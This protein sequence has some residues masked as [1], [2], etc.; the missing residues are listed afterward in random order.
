MIFNWTVL[1]VA[2]GV[3]MVYGYSHR[4]QAPRIS[5]APVASMT[6]FASADPSSSERSNE[7][8]ATAEPSADGAGLAVVQ[9]VPF[10]SGDD[11]SND[12]QESPDASE[13]RED[14]AALVEA[15]TSN[16]STLKQLG[17]IRALGDQHSSPEVL[18]A[19]RTTL[20]SDVPPINRIEAIKS[21]H[22][23]AKR[24]G[25]PSGEIRAAIAAAAQ[26]VNGSIARVAARA[27]AESRSH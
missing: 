7:S 4:A 19:L 21:L 10:Q 16:P 11:E 23:L 2:Y 12:R 9:S 6:E 14:V 15:A 3:F 26:D 24:N 20:Q 17:A 22:R 13:L 1:L 25:D 8:R 27:Q 18:Q 5:V